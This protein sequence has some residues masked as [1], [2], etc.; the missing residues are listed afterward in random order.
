MITKNLLQKIVHEMEYGDP[1]HQTYITTLTE[2]KAALDAWTDEP[3]RQPLSEAQIDEVIAE[4][5]KN[6]VD[7]LT[8]TG[9]QQRTLLDGVDYHIVRAIERA[10]GIGG[11]V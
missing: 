1:D 9:G 11:E 3:P 2:A 4:A 8:R 10:H 7:H 6:Y 5:S